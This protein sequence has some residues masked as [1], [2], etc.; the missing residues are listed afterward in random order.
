MN[1]TRKLVRGLKKYMLCVFFL[2]EFKLFIFKTIYLAV[3]PKSVH[4]F[5]SEQ[6]LPPEAGLTRVTWPFFCGDWVGVCV[7]TALLFFRQDVLEGVFRKFAPSP[8]K[9]YSL[10]G[11]SGIGM[12]CCLSF[13][14]ILLNIVTRTVSGKGNRH[15]SQ[16]SSEHGYAGLLLGQSGLH[17]SA[18]A[19]EE[20]P[21]AASRG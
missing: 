15:G 10:T 3:Y 8:L 16:G 14:Y 7:V 6:F 11:F 5:K 4:C 13:M 18:K 19:E 21:T 1:K 17:C 12:F 2:V 20:L 9:G